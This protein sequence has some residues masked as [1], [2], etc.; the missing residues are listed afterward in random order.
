MTW[1]WPYWA[2]VWVWTCD[3]YC[4]CL[5]E[6]WYIVPLWER[7]MA[8]SYRRGPFSVAG[9]Q[10]E[11]YVSRENSFTWHWLVV[12]VAMETFPPSCIRAWLV[13]WV[14]VILLPPLS[15]PLQTGHHQ[16][17]VRHHQIQVAVNTLPHIT[18]TDKWFLTVRRLV[19]SCFC[20]LC[21]GI[22][23]SLFF[24]TSQIWGFVPM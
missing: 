1:Q 18:P 2:L 13:I 4:P 14:K 20:F 7:M 22:H 24:V 23:A 21:S 9:A 10:H 19:V 11:H 3:R 16:R 5:P 8:V 12:S 15:P 17:H 6:R